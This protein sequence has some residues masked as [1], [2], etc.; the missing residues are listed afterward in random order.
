M[1]IAP[2]PEFQQAF[3]RVT[4]L[5]CSPENVIV[6]LR[7]FPDLFQEVREMH[8]DIV[9]LARQRRLITELKQRLEKHKPNIKQE[10]TE[11]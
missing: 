4:G 7:E 10:E 2:T 9:M 1:N 11:R 8:A 6:T 5:E 3:K